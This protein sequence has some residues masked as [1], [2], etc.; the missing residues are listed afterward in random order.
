[1]TDCR[2]CVNRDEGR[3]SAVCRKCN[4]NDTYG[5]HYREH[6]AVTAYKELELEQKK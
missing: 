1:M 3:E 6:P 5:C 4:C 2:T